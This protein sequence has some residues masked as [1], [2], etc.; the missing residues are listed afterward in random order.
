MSSIDQTI[1][2]LSSQTIQTGLSLDSRGIEWIVN[3][4]LLAAAALFPVA[5]KLADVLGYKRM[6]LAGTIAFAIGSFCAG[7]PRRVLSRWRG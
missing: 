4:Y 2:S 6:M 1:V 3:S 5:G 7:S